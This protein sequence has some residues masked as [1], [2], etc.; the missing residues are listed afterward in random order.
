MLGIV[1]NLLQW[2]QLL[3]SGITAVA[4]MK[5]GGGTRYSEEIVKFEVLA[6]NPGGMFMKH[7]RSW[8]QRL[9]M[10]LAWET[11][12]CQSPKGGHAGN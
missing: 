9:K 1:I 6:E 7:L 3:V 8:N 5:L 4:W 2:F 11:Q 10:R 12:M